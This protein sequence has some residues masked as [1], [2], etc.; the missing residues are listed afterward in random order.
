MSQD[1]DQ[2]TSEFGLLASG[3]AGLWSID[4]DESL[5]R[6]EWCIDLDGPRF[7]LRFQ[8]RNL[9]VVSDTIQYVRSGLAWHS[10]HQGESGPDTDELLLGRFGSSS[11]FLRWDN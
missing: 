8:L 2:T 3:S 7:S 1:V 6:E 11:V 10:V 5:F 4:I 9:Q